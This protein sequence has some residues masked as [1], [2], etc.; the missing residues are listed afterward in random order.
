[1]K[2][3]SDVVNGLEGSWRK[4][5]IPSSNV[6]VFVALKSRKSVLFGRNW[7]YPLMGKKEVVSKQLQ[8]A[9]LILDNFS[10]YY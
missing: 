8:Q 6:Q 1:M 4:T 10:T 9:A 3:L 7:H 2:A 5:S